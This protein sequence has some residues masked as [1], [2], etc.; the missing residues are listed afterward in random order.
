MMGDR[1]VLQGVR[2]DFP[3]LERQVHG[4]R[5]VYLDN[6]ASTQMPR[7]VMQAMQDFELDSRANIHRGVH[8]RSQQRHRRLRAAARTTLKRPTSAP[9]RRT[10]LVFCSRHHRGAQPGR[11]RP[12]G[13]RPMARPGCGRATR[14]SS[15]ALEHHANLLP[16]Q[17]RGAA[18][19]RA[20]AHP[21][22][23]RATAR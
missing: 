18:Q 15:A 12:V 6:A 16:W 14:S 17:A 19:R 22:A 2:A 4:R 7:Q 10:K 23:R 9:M 3:G 1:L 20:P 21:A 8:A 5:L 11:L 13:R